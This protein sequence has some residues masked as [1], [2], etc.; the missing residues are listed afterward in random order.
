MEALVQAFASWTALMLEAVAVLMVAVGAVGALAQ[1]ALIGVRRH[2]TERQLHVT[3]IGFGR[4]L[5]AA[6]S[7]QLGADIVS[8]TIAPTWEE[9]GRLAV[10]ATIRTFLS[11]F[12]D[13]DLAR[14]Q[15]ELRAEEGQGERPPD[16]G[17]RTGSDG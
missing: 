4:W 10:L 11:F 15:Q 8:T 7:F 6:L 5:V 1:V 16:P 17:M 12:L 13:H 3:F 2:A 14:A 9:L